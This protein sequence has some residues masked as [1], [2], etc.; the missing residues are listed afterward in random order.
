MGRTF[1]GLSILSL[2]YP[3][4]PF[5]LLSL[6]GRAQHDCNIVDWPIKPQLKNRSSGR[7]ALEKVTHKLAFSE[8]VHEQYWIITRLCNTTHDPQAGFSSIVMILSFRTPKTFVVI[9]L[10]FELCGFT[11]D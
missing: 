6:L 11:I 3:I 2:V 9:T 5:S 4:N 10:K 1:S 7:Y 8:S